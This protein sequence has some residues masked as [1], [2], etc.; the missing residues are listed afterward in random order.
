MLKVMI[1]H[2]VP[3]DHDQAADFLDR[4]HSLRVARLG[5]LLHPLRHPALLALDDGRIVAVATYVARSDA[6]EILTLHSDRRWSGI[7]TDLVAAV[8]EVAVS[9]GCR[10]L[11]LVT[12]NDNVDALRFYQRRGFRMAALHPGAV[13]RSRAELKPEIPAVGEHGIALHDELVLDKPL[14]ASA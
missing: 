13:D 4:H 8:E 5:E 12:T 1:R 9:R 2:R 11:W 6:V 7:G 10:R 3:D 14:P